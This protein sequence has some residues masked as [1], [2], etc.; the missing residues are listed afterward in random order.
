MELKLINDTGISSTKK[1]S[2][3]LVRITKELG[4]PLMGHIAFGILSR[5]QNNLIQIRPTTICNLNCQFCSTDGGPFSKYHKTNY[6]VEVNYLLQ[7]IKE[8]AKIKGHNLIAHIDS[9][10]DPSTYPDLVE[11]VKGIKKIGNFREIALQTN[12][13][14]LTSRL[15]DDLKN[16]GLDKLHLSIHSLDAEQAG[17]LMGNSSYDIGKVIEIARYIV[18]K[19]I[20]LWINPVYLPS[21]N[22]KGIAEIITLVKELNCNIGL[23]KYNRHRYGRKMKI[24]QESWYSFYKNLKRLEKEYSIKLIHSDGFEKRN[25]L[26]LA[27][28]K[29]EKILAL[30][31]AP[32]WFGNQMLATARNRCITVNDCG[33]RVNDLVKVKVIENKNNIYIADMS[34][35]R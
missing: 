22:D 23:Q 35:S 5:S 11:L 10:G 28:R 27:I 12:G 14:L 17:F 8:V 13:T 31:K 7:W 18:K 21:I 6:I 34:T 30:V 29:N 3:A 25:N 2:M 24:K 33:A 1:D 4:I 26:P 16:A 19:G 9:V 15:V 32:G 20:D